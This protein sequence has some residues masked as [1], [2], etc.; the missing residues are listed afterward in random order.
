MGEEWLVK[1]NIYKDEQNS[2][3]LKQNGFQASPG[4]Q[5]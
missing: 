1:V 3:I 5:I 4:K 2:H